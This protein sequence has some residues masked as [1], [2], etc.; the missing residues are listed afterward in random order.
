ME[1]DHAI[2]AARETDH[3]PT[4]LFALALTALTHI[5]S[6]DHVAAT[7]HLEECIPLA[8]GKAPYIKM[9]AAGNRGCVWAQTGKASDA[10]QA[11]NAEIGGLRGIGAT[12]WFTSWFAHLALAYAELG[13]FEDA[14]R[15]ISEAMTL[16]EKS[17]ERWYQAE[18]D[19]VA[20]EI[21]LMS[22]ERD[23]RK[24]EVYFER[25]LSVSRQQQ[26][27]SWE[28]GA[29]ISLAR[30][31]RDQGKRDAALNLLAPV[32]NWFTEGFD[33]LDLKEAKALLEKLAT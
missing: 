24:A 6:R 10:I 7:M 29:A 32:Y 1:T 3:L 9:F 28:L 8:Q 20:G 31:W 18:I 17:K 13:K 11:I 33:T 26:A 22:H 21:A 4:L 27:K 5:C 25:A 15:C 12:V 16:V 14:W 30:L 23:A 2:A 19:R